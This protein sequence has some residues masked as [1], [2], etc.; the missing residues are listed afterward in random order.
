MQKKC[1]RHLLPHSS[2]GSTLHEVGPVGLFRT[3]IIREGC[4][5]GSAMV[6][7]ERAMVVSYWL[8]IVTTALS[9][10]IRPQFA[11]YCLRHSNLQRVNMGKSWGGRGD[12]CNC[13]ILTPSGRDMRLS[14]AKE[15]LSISSAV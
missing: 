4:H 14:Y 13:Q 7:F 3:P 10:T 12:R 8:S 6:P 11:I 2:G 9:L 5:K 15:I 1:C